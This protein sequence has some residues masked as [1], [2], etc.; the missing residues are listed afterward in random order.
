M[1]E[2]FSKCW[3]LKGY[4]GGSGRG[5]AIS[6]GN[7][8]DRATQRRTVR[9]DIQEASRRTNTQALI[10]IFPDEVPENEM[11][12]HSSRSSRR[13]ELSSQE[14]TEEISSFLFKL[15]TTTNPFFASLSSDS[16]TEI[17]SE[18]RKEE[19]CSP[20]SAGQSRRRFCGRSLDVSFCWLRRL[21]AS[22]W[23]AVH[24]LPFIDARM[25]GLRP[26]ADPRLFRRDECWR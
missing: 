25:A 15:V 8:V 26:S 16:R 22:R 5:I 23:I 21:V 14:R 10:V 18:N 24:D 7:A 11:S 3:K 4:G 20:N 19:I 13:Q 17:L 2:T 6:H 9:F 12:V 1:N